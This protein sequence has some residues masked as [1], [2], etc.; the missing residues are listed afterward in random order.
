MTR[1]AL[2]I[3]FLVL[4]ANAVLRE[5]PG[6]RRPP[7]VRWP[8]DAR[9]TERVAGVKI[10]V[11]PRSVWLDD[12]DTLKITWASE[13]RETVRI[14]GIDAPEV[15]HSRDPHSEDQPYGRESLAFARH[16]IQNAGKLEILRARRPDRYGRTLA[17][18]FVNDVNYSVLAIEN[19]MAESTIDR[20]GDSGLPVE[21]EQVRQAA[22]RAGPLPFESPLLFRDRMAQKRKA[23]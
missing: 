2:I 16:L 19:H 21:A 10:A 12:G 23:G 11:D 4:L 13:P 6:L 3:A 8:A 5:R 7:V 20:F 15:R 17:Y 14:L 1:W 18:L 9:T 22:R